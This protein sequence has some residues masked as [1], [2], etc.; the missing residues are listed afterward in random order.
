MGYYRRE[1]QSIEVLSPE[2]LRI[3]R[4]MF[5]FRT[6]GVLLDEL[7][8][9]DMIEKFEKEGLLEI[10]ENKVFLTST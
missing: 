3:E 6:S 7:G 9:T 8:N 1:K 10:R 5:G 4:I 2:S